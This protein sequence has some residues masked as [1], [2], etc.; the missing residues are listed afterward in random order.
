M[1]SLFFFKHFKMKG[2]IVGTLLLIIFASLELVP[3]NAQSVHKDIQEAKTRAV[4]YENKRTSVDDITDN[5][6]SEENNNQDQSIIQEGNREGKKSIKRSHP[7]VCPPGW[8]SPW[9]YVDRSNSGCSEG[10]G[11]ACN[12]GCGGGCEEDGCDNEYGYD[13]C[14]CDG[15]GGCGECGCRFHDG[16]VSRNRFG[17]RF[18]HTFNDGL[19]QHVWLIGKVPMICL[20]V[21]EM[22]FYVM[23]L[24][25]Y[26]LQNGKKMVHCA[27]G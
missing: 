1:K 23:K 15:E 13:E 8:L 22:I 11:G 19:I 3:S 25:S 17:R 24:R 26:K 20:L 5:N 7:Q 12:C 6:E 4:E 14:D 27:K 18:P 16:F 21:L 10:N 9:D 2:F